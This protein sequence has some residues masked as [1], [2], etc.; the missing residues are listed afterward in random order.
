MQLNDF[1]IF[2]VNTFDEF[3]DLEQKLFSTELTSKTD[4]TIIC[5]ENKTFY[6]Y[7]SVV[8]LGEWRLVTDGERSFT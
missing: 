6:Y 8:D 3:K 5:L 2:T 7:T 4:V 1:N